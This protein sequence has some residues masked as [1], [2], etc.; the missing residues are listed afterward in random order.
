VAV[1]ARA[2][3]QIISLK[4]VP[5]MQVQEGD[6]LAEIDPTT[7]ENNLKTGKSPLPTTAPDWTKRKRSLCWPGKIWNGRRA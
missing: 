3:G 7:E 6:L 1:G 5:G 2:T 4:A